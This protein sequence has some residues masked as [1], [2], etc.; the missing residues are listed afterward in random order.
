[1][2]AVP[3]AFPFQVSRIGLFSKKLPLME[4]CFTQVAPLQGFNPCLRL[5]LSQQLLCRVKVRDPHGFYFLRVFPLSVRDI[6]GN[7][8]SHELGGR[9]RIKPL[10][11]RVLPTESLA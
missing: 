7:P 11:F 6:T 10:S 2:A 3:A 4:Q 8:P 9:I 5:F 1:M